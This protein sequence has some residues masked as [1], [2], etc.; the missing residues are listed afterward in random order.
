MKSEKSN[1]ST[2]VY[3]FLIIGIIIG[4][5]IGFGVGYLTYTSQINSLNSKITNLQTSFNNSLITLASNSPPFAIGAAG[6]LKYAFSSILST[7]E[8]QYP[9]I[10]VA[11]PL[12]E[13]S[14]LV[15]QLENT[16]QEFSL[17]A[18]ADTTA[19]PS[20]LF[21]NLANYE[22][23]FGQTQMVI[24]VN[25]ESPAGLQLYNMWKDVQ[26]L[27]VMSTQWNQT[28]QQMFTLIAINSSTIVGVSN[29]FT[30]PSGYQ[31]A[32]M[33][34]LA[35]LTFFGN[36]TYLYNAIYNNPSK[37][38]MANTETNL[39]TFIQTQHIDF[40]ISAY[41]SNAIPQV[42]NSTQTN[43]AYITLPDLVNLGVLSD[44]SYYQLANFN[45][46]ELGTTESFVV[47]PVIYTVTIPTSS[48]NA[49]AAALFIQTLFSQTGQSILEQNGITPI[50]P[51]IVYGNYTSIP[52][53]I[54]S[55]VTPVNATYS[56]LFPGS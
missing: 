4:C 26:G 17:E 44:L 7:F 9:S 1:R 19:M 3:S 2:K 35:G 34:R 43:L 21:P 53:L 16:T 39:V 8:G 11:P 5:A 55:F 49:A 52:S 20:V 50:S 32:G 22:I 15:A 25:L 36:V 27:P 12:F 40:I 48:T 13:G 30:D 51:G 38:Y 10:K 47:N 46:T 28:W 37:Y 14:S 23:A 31:A 42:G 24:I 33:I 18:A 56:T 41:L 29:P 45:Y 6:T 54:E